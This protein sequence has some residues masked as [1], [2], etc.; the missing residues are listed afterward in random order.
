M[1]RLS[2]TLLST[3]MPSCNCHSYAYDF[4]LGTAYMSAYTDMYWQPLA[5][6]AI[7]IFLALSCQARQI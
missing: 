5:Y 3:M 6:Y 7:E 1:A 2:G 4:S